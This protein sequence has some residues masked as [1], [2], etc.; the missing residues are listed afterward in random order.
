MG[1]DPKTA[2]GQEPDNEGVSELPADVQARIDAIVERRLQRDRRVRG[3]AEGKARTLEQELESLRARLAAAQ[4][5]QGELERTKQEHAQGAAEA[6]AWK[7]RYARAA[8][9]RLIG[10]QLEAAGVVRGARDLLTERALASAQVDLGGEGEVNITIDGEALPQAVARLLADRPDLLAA[11]PGG[12]AGSGGSPLASN[13]QGGTVAS[14]E[15]V[16]LARRQGRLAERMSDPDFARQAHQA[17]LRRLGAG[18][19]SPL[20]QKE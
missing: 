13:P 2:Y 16:L 14:F 4:E 17:L 11:P 1:D 7:T 18:G 19:G 12:G 15:Q 9:T 5:A 3:D 8:A 6:D 20:S 10:E